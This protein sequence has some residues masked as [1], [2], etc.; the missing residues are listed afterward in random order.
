MKARTVLPELL[1]A[2]TEKCHFDLSPNEEWPKFDC[3]KEKQKLDLL[4][5]TL[6][7]LYVL[8]LGNRIIRLNVKVHG[9]KQ[10]DGW[11]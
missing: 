7:R 5:V 8:N 6:N 4:G 10:T 3:N 9:V 11:S 1:K 2:T